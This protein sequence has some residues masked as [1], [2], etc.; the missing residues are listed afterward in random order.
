MMAHHVGSDPLPMCPGTG[1]CQAPMQFPP[2][3]QDMS[4]SAEVEVGTRWCTPDMGGGGIIVYL[5]DRWYRLVV[6]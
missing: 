4:Q 3:E 5:F 1:I 2:F 6:F